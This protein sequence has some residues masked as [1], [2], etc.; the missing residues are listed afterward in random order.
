MGPRRLLAIAGFRRLLLS[1]FAAQWGDGLFQ[2]GLAGAVVFNPERGASPLAIAAG[3]TVLLLPYSLVGPFAGALLDRWDRRRVLVA[4]N[5]LRGAL[6]LVCALCVATGVSGSVLLLLALLVI[7]ISRFVLSGLSAALP[8]VVPVRNLVEGN[9]LA[10]TLGALIAVFGGICAVGLRALWGAGN[11]GSGLT[12]AVAAAGSVAAAAFAIRFAR[13]ELGPDKVDEPALALWAV[14]RGLFDGGRAA[15]RAPTVAAGFI[16]LF[17]HR[18]AVGISFLL[19]VLLM[20]YSF[21]DM[22]PL[23]AGLPGLAE[24]FAAGGLGILVAGLTTA[25]LV[26]RIGR[27]RSISAALMLAAVAQLGLGLLMTLPSVLLATFVIL[28]AGQ[29][30]KLCVDA[31]VQRD[32]GDETRGR[33]FA[34]YDTLFNITQVAGVA[35]AAAVVPMNGRSATLIVVA[36][37]LYLAGLAGFQLVSRRHPAQ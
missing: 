5:L 16:A 18:A 32:I 34:L 15:L 10:T 33:V 27:R 35:L 1:R 24:I 36:A 29:V 20:R 30:V 6:I 23:K 14:V 11:V 26:G 21:T 8:H 22:G 4:A 31:A 37:G 17:A 28:Y 12:T 19:T 9:A 13:G 3:F 2:A 25:R 7:G